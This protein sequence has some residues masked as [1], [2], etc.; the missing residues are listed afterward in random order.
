MLN[1]TAIATDGSL[2]EEFANR[3]LNILLDE[4][5][6]YFVANEIDPDVEP[7]EKCEEVDQESCENILDALVF[8]TATYLSIETNGRKTMTLL[9]G[10]RYCEI[11]MEKINA[12]KMKTYATEEERDADIAKFTEARSR[13]N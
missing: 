6:A 13:V 1:V 11:L 12:C 3:I 7:T 8:A 10:E 5:K 9:L 4:K 2:K